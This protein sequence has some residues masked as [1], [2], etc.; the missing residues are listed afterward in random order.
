[1]QLANVATEKSSRKVCSEALS[2]FKVNFL[3]TSTF[4]DSQAALLN[5]LSESDLERLGCKDS[6]VDITGEDLDNCHDNAK[7]VNTDDLKPLDR[8]RRN[9]SMKYVDRLAPKIPVKQNSFMSTKSSSTFS[10]MRPK[11]FVTDSGASTPL[12]P[13]QKGLANI[14]VPS[15]Q[16]TLNQPEP[17]TMV[18]D[19]TETTS[20][21]LDN[22]QVTSVIV[23]TPKNEIGETFTYPETTIYQSHASCTDKLEGRS[24][25]PPK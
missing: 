3:S 17:S 5:T 14:N 21:T 25:N 16:T 24:Q 6:A 8:S 23:T 2:G 10:S 7:Y 1:M 9:D 15:G 19:L 18:I 12:P 4:R 11:S 20:K 13:K 22:D